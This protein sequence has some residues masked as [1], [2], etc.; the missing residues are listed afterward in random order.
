MV[1]KD[2]LHDI[3]PVRRSCAPDGPAALALSLVLGQAETLPISRTSVDDSTNPRL[4][5]REYS[6]GQARVKSRRRVRPAGFLASTK[7]VRR[8]PMRKV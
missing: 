3:A 2:Y 1:C 7:K 6:S 8:P 4:I 5:G